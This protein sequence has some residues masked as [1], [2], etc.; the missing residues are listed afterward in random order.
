MQT[1][2]VI[3]AGGQG[4]RLG[5]VRKGDLRL[6]GVPLAV[7]AYR[8]LMPQ[9]DAIL[10]SLPSM[11]TEPATN[12]TIA[13]P[14]DPVG[15]AGPAAGLYAAAGWCLANA[16][17]ARLVSMAVDTPFFPVDFVSRAGESSTTCVVGAF[18]DSTYPTNALWFPE[19]L[20]AVLQ[21]IP[22]AARGPRLGDVLRK[23]GASSLDYARIESQ[24]PFAG[25]NTLS[26]LLELSRRFPSISGLS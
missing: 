7:H 16:P 15:P 4:Q 26:D 5:G 12:G 1:I 14:D 22:S 2:G 3:L 8:R 20:L 23:M 24:N 10:M 18:D 9:C 21:A 11:S 6:G 25:V 17:G 13:L 19:P